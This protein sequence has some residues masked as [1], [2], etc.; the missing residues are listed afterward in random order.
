MAATRSKSIVVGKALPNIPWE[1]RA[2]GFGQALVNVRVAFE[3]T[4]AS[5]GGG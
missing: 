5:G 2:A 3:V 1:T 4:S